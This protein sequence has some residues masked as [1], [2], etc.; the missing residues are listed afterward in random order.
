[1]IKGPNTPKEIIQPNYK[2]HKPDDTIE[3]VG[4]LDDA[5][6]S[7]DPGIVHKILEDSANWKSIYYR[8]TEN[9]ENFKMLEDAFDFL[10]ERDL[11]K[12][13]YLYNEKANIYNV[14][15]EDIIKWIHGTGF[16]ED[17]LNESLITAY[18]DRNERRFFRIYN[19]ILDS[20][21]EN[22]LEDKNMVLKAQH[23]FASWQSSVVGGKNKEQAKNINES[24]IDFD[25]THENV[26][27]VFAAKAEYGAINDNPGIKP[28]QKGDS[29]IKINERFKSLGDEFD[30][31]Q[32]TN[33]AAKAYFELGKRQGQMGPKEQSNSEENI[34]LAKELALEALG[35][36]IAQKYTNA[37]IKAR[38]TLGEI[39]AY[40]GDVEKSRSYSNKAGKMRKTYHY[41]TK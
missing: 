9:L 2:I 38:E 16:P 14:K 5:L 28:R 35:K 8:R 29:F 20:D 27:P 10:I 41:Y 13:D 22:L 15:S 19:I 6:K 18:H 12:L 7:K 21:N 34:G 23:A 39:Y 32:A 26:D 37:E 31:M 17:V 36:A 1:M 25:K 4:E 24:I 33:E 30:S 3:I 11:S 40:V